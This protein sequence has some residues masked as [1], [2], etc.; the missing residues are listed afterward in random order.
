MGLDEIYTL[1][2]G[3]SRAVFT[4]MQGKPTGT[5]TDKM[6]AKKF[7][8]MYFEAGDYQGFIDRNRITIRG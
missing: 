1:T 4:L 2:E 8:D 3:Q 7:K 6:F 5:D